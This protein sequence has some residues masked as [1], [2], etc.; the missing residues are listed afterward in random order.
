MLFY[1]TH[2][3]K[4]L[5]QWRTRQHTFR[6]HIIAQ[7]KWKQNVI[8]DRGN[9]RRHYTYTYSDSYAH[10]RTYKQTNK[11]TH[12]HTHTHTRTYIH[13][14]TNAYNAG[15]LQ[16]FRNTNKSHRGH[17]AA[18]C[19]VDRDMDDFETSAKSTHTAT[20]WPW[21]HG[22]EICSTQTVQ[23]IN[24]IIVCVFVCLCVCVCMC[25]YLPSTELQA[26]TSG[27]KVTSKKRSHA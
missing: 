12:T 8:H 1:N 6:I 27:H 7:K 13:T 23:R 19:S 21:I 18:S 20:V 9:V 16:T 22:V 15:V 25:V 24:Q 4:T 5:D 26:H 2:K 11:Q 10:I 14:H 17:N 3:R